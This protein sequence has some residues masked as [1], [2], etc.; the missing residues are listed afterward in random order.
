[1]ANLQR[2]AVM[3]M[4]P[5]HQRIESTGARGGWPTKYIL[6][7]QHYEQHRSVRCW[8]VYAIADQCR[9]RV[10]QGTEWFGLVDWI[11][12]VRT[13]LHVPDC[14][15][16]SGE[17]QAVI[18]MELRFTSANIRIGCTACLTN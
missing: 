8:L 6:D 9:P 5:N 2:T 12:V 15:L 7:P 17:A 3:I 13:H 4:P 18:D 1:V 10:D 16:R 14:G 11:D